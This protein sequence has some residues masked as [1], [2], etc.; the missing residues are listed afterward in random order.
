MSL[1]RPTA[2]YLLCF[3]SFE[4]SLQTLDQSI[5]SLSSDYSFSG[6]DEW[7]ACVHHKLYFYDWLSDSKLFQCMFI[8]C[9]I[10]PVF[11]MFAS[12]FKVLTGSSL[13]IVLARFLAWRGAL[14]TTAPEPRQ[15]RPQPRED[16]SYP[17]QL[18]LWE[19]ES[20]RRWCP[21]T[22]SATNH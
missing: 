15:R 9:Y 19:M 1:R 17:G 11:V 21:R 12:T 5:Y 22:A 14:M 8:T 13:A 3:N 18:F 4:A 6:Y 16:R 2:A 7:P 10:M 20:H